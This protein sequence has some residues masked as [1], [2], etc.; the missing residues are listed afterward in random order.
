M[1]DITDLI[2]RW[3]KQMLGVF[4]L[5]VL[6]V[7]VITFLKPRQYLSIATAVPASSFA[8]DKSKIFSD[9][10]QSLYSALGTPDDLD[11]VLGTSKLDTVYLA[12]TDA[13]NLF[14][15]YKMKETGPSARIRAAWR[16]KKNT[17]VMKSEYGELKV[18]TWDT[19]KDLAPQLANA[20]MNQ[21]QSIHQHLQSAGNEATLYGLIKGKKRLQVRLDSAAGLVP[22]N[23][24]QLQNQVLQYEK[25]ISEYQLLV[26]S[27]PPSLIV[28]EKAT[29]SLHPDKPQ[30]VKI[31]VATALLS[32]LFSLL[33]A[34]VLDR[35]KAV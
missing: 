1:P 23:K 17:T 9:N 3:W 7:G 5:S 2:G 6:A 15:H 21:L 11:R 32:L 22:D 16:L 24:N 10:V 13:F 28:V 4:L 8:A 20:L 34:L 19:D 35:P 27:K 30:R 33:A 31:L 12:V 25:L 18:K 26:D 14:D 29:A